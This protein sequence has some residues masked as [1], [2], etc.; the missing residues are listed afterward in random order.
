MTRLAVRAYRLALLAVPREVRAAHGED[1]AAVFGALAADARRRGRLALARTLAAEL[2]D[3]ARLAATGRRLD[4]LQARL[5]DLDIAAA[6]PPGSH[7]MLSALVLDL[8]YAVRL[9]RRTPTFTFVS[10]S[11]IA[12]AIGA[13]TAIFTVFHDIVLKPLPFDDPARIVL[14]AER[15]RDT[16]L[17]Q[18]TTP[19]TIGD[20]MRGATAFTATAAF[21]S[22]TRVVEVDGR[23]ERLGGCLSVGDLFGVLGRAAADGRTLTPADDDPGAPPVVVLSTGLARRL[24]GAGSPVGRALTINAEAYT[25]VGVMPPDFAFFDFTDEYWIPAR[26][27]AAFRGNRD[28]YFLAGVGRLA[29]GIGIDG[30]EAQLNTV[31]D[32]VRRD[33]PQY[34]QNA[35]AA[36][37]PAKDVLLDGNERRLWLLMGAV[38]FVLLIACANLGNL[39]LARGTERRA[40]MAVRRAVGAGSGRLFRQTLVESV[41]LAL[42]GGAL[43]VAL[44]AGLVRVLVALLPQDLPRLAGVGL[45]LP[46]VGFALAATTL[47]GLCFGTFPAVQLLAGSPA[48][49]LRDGTRATS[50]E[51]R[52]RQ[53]LVVSQLALALVLLAGAGLLTRSLVALMQVR[54]GFDSA[55]LLTF[56][57]PLA[58]EVYR[59]LAA[60]VAFFERAA[61]ALEALPAA[62]SV[63]FTMTLPVDGRGVGAWFN[64][65][66]RPW[67]ADRTPPAVPYRVVRTNYF[68][69]LGIPILRGRAFEEADGTAGRAAVVIS[70]S[71]ARR[72]YADRDPIGRHLFMGAPGN[73][74]IPDAEIVGVAADVKQRGLD[75]QSSE[76]VY[77]PSALVPWVGTMAFAIRTTVDPD[78]FAASAREALRRIDPGVPLV[79]VRTMDDIMSTALAPTRSTMVLV[80]IFAATAL[81]LAVVG[82][83]GVLSYTVSQRTAEFGIRMALGATGSDVRRHVLGRGVAQVA[84][85]IAVGLAGAV[86]LARSMT[87][88][89]YGVTATDP[90]TLAAVSLLLAAAALG[91]A[92]LPAL[93]ATRIDPAA[94][95]RA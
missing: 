64:M 42:A 45:D 40:E 61:Q 72:Y 83:F 16:G 4:P 13:N 44:A 21:A 76:T 53:A 56:S 2:V 47:A 71:V 12:L 50:R 20:L 28:Q 6:R 80:G 14:F 77:A 89:L 85:G 65:A 90:L 43:G 84:L 69:A 37:R 70:E 62:R 5:V 39:L 41:V 33:Y 11:T 34:T 78:A 26:F 82:V 46:A 30:A 93:R 36:V 68:Q 66:D 74:V 24:F 8:R 87:S 7:P 32:A 58:S 23:A 10:V 81:I 1:M 57:T 75:E 31:M 88:L 59:P 9:L 25:V 55:R 95:L 92:Y 63:T 15:A 86:A 60:R 54:P 67:P 94:V 3:L 73:H 91:A 19:G 18:T 51:G 38:G 17:F 22:T 79:G 48:G 52:A 49:A 29:P 35:D 27:D